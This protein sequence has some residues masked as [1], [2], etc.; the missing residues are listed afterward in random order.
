MPCIFSNSSCAEGKQLQA[1]KAELVEKVSFAVEVSVEA[2]SESVSTIRVC[3]HVQ[4][5]FTAI[6]QGQEGCSSRSRARKS[7][8][9]QEAVNT[10]EALIAFRRQEAEFNRH[11]HVTAAFGFHFGELK[12]SLKV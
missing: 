7:T 11:P 9:K 4:N 10:L 5:F 2:L 3:G 12:P 8:D 1:Q 6:P